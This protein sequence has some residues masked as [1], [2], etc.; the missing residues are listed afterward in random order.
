[1]YQFF[2]RLDFTFPKDWV[3]VSSK[4]FGSKNVA[5]S[6]AFSINYFVIVPLV[7]SDITYFFPSD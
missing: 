5:I 7:Q 4:V 1:M 3:T 6:G 2:A